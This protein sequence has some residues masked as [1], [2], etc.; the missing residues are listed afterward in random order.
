MKVIG[1]GEMF[2]R[3]EARLGRAAPA[4]VA[5]NNAATIG[6]LQRYGVGLHRR[7]VDNG[8]THTRRSCAHCAQGVLTT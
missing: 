7:D 4:S 8:A 3:N 6:R 5:A 1:G 2:D